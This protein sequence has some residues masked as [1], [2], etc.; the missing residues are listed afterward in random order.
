MTLIA[1]VILTGLL[2]D[3][4]A[5][6]AVRAFRAAMKSTEVSARVA[7]VSELGK[8]RHEKV[9]KV[10]AT[11]LI[12]DEKEVRIQAADALGQFNVRKPQVC[13]L[14]SDALEMN[15]RSPEVESAILKALKELGEE[16]A[17]GPAYRYMDDKN[18]K[19]AEAAIGILG[20]VR[21]KA[22]IEPLLKLMK[23]L[24]HS[25]EGYNS[26]D[27]SL[28][29]PEDEQL[30]QR[31]RQLQ[32]AACKALQSITGEKWSTSEDWESWWKKNAATFKVK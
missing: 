21:Y 7:A 2:D 19:V 11:C 27:G 5:D 9:L 4:E 3:K 13:G 24:I 1:F 20:V 25:G 12:I 15:R 26:G 30:R 6:E 29:V 16:G 14:L 10:L 31:A 32:A 23:K 18:S 22:S 28:D 17:L 8:C